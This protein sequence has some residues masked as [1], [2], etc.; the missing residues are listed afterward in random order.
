M[1]EEDSIP[2]PIT[3]PPIVKSSISG[4]TGIVH[5]KGFKV[6]VNWPI[7][8]NGST[9]TVYVNLLIIIYQ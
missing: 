2:V 5:P 1:W 6:A 9:R 8:T 7:V 3:R 4:K